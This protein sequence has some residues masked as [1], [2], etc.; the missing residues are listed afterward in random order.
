MKQAVVYTHKRTTAHAY[1]IA[2]FSCVLN[3]FSM[4]TYRHSHI[5]YL[6]DSILRMGKQMREI[7]SDNNLRTL[8]YNINSTRDLSVG[9]LSQ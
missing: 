2:F 7:F 9:V 8:P 5:V 4:L 1:M 6:D 3:V